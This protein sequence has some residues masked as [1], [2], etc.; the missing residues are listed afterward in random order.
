[1]TQKQKNKTNSKRPKLQQYVH[2]H[3]INI[4][5]QLNHSVYLQS[6]FIPHNQLVSLDR[7]YPVGPAIISYIHMEWKGKKQ[8]RK[9]RNDL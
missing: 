8:N 5:P 2:H 1:M 4:Q 3:L 6:A 9:E 7:W